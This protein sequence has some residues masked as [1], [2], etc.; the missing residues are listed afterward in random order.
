MYFLFLLSISYFSFCR[1]L[2]SETD[3]HTKPVLFSA[4][5]AHRNPFSLLFGLEFT[6]SLTSRKKTRK[7]SRLIY[8][9]W[10]WRASHDWHTLQL[11]SAPCAQFTS[12][13]LSL[14]FSPHTVIKHSG[15]CVDGKSRTEAVSTFPLLYS[16]M[17]PRAQ[18][19]LLS[20][21]MADGKVL[22]FAWWFNEEQTDISG[23]KAPFLLYSAGKIFKQNYSCCKLLPFTFKA[24]MVQNC[25]EIT[26]SDNRLSW[27]GTIRTIKSTSAHILPWCQPGVELGA[28]SMSQ[29]DKLLHLLLANLEPSPLKLLWNFSFKTALDP[30]QPLLLNDPLAFPVQP[31]LTPEPC[32]GFRKEQGRQQLSLW[33][34]SELS[35]SLAG[36]AKVTVIVGR[37]FLIKQKALWA[38]GSPQHLQSTALGAS[39][40]LQM[41]T[42]VMF[43]LFIWSLM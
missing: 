33:V 18:L 16:T 42:W 9:V 30:E 31:L 3:S 29:E 32:P 36:V 27:N 8:L 14:S 20:P 28:Q 2:C 41:T 11:S 10:L 13:I 26:E 35:H 1:A 39:G 6:H 43:W 25:E 19:L 23:A 22:R 24:T 40:P 15:Q 7:P 5:L 17:C 12:Q 37:F 38:T 34:R 4:S 21:H